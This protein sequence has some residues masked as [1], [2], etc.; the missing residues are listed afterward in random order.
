[1]KCHTTT[2]LK[3]WQD[4]LYIIQHHSEQSMLLLWQPQALFGVAP[5]QRKQQEPLAS[6]LMKRCPRHADLRMAHINSLPMLMLLHSGNIA[7]TP[8]PC[9]LNPE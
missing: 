3:T 8:R 4:S 1:M 6:M 2:S 5:V 7:N 9:A